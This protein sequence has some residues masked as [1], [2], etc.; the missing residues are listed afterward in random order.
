MVAIRTILSLVLFH[1]ICLCV[2]A[3]TSLRTEILSHAL[4]GY[5]NGKWYGLAMAKSSIDIQSVGNK[6]VRGNFK[7]SVWADSRGSSQFSI[8]LDFSISRANMQFRIPVGESYR[9]RIMTGKGRISWGDG[10]L[11][12]AADVLF[13]SQADQIDFTAAT[14]R[15]ESTWLFSAFLPLGDFSFFEP[16]ISL[17]FTIPSLLAKSLQSNTLPEFRNL[18]TGARFQGK[19]GELK[20]ELGYLFTGIDLVHH[21]TIS[22][23]AHWLVDWYVALSTPLFHPLPS[24]FRD[25]HISAGLF[26]VQN[27]GNNRISIRVE[28]LVKIKEEIYQ[29]FSEFLFSIGSSYSLSIRGL[30]RYSPHTKIPHSGTLVLG[31]QAG[32]IEGLSIEPYLTYSPSSTNFEN[33]SFSVLIR[34]IF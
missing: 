16:F 24:D 29:L 25:I 12:N 20:W 30:Y 18:K 26:H 15:D 19:I 3:E 10:I 23:Q 4:G 7:L 5:Q 32:I 33:A 28:T 34:Y 2:L 31:F 27:V 14:I 21:P 9:F 11:F 8:P 1:S 6:N 13:G 22:L 17:P